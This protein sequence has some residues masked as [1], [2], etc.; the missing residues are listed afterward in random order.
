MTGLNINGFKE[1]LI[2]Q[3]CEI[4]PTTNEYETLR[5]KGR[6]VGV[7]YRSG[8]T[9]NN[10]TV[11][12]IKCFLKKQAWNGRPINIGRKPGYVKEKIKLLERD[13]NKCF[14]CGLPLEE[15]I[16]VEHLLSLV[17]GGPNTLSNMVLAHEECNQL[18]GILTIVE[19]I[20][21]AIRMRSR[22]I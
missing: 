12:A 9:S 13:G 11:H 4:L 15:D 1:W 22:N 2:L 19:K 17:S 16:T 10:Y 3:G 6:E 7:V 14:Y 20:N 21:L 5:F 8:K 18:A